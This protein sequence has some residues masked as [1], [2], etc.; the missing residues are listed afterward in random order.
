MSRLYRLPDEL[1]RII[2]EYSHNMLFRDVVVQLLRTVKWDL[3]NL[4][5]FPI[6][7][8]SPS[9]SSSVILFKNEALARSAIGW[10]YVYNRRT[11]DMY[12]H[13]ITVMGRRSVDSFMHAIGKYQRFSFVE[14]KNYDKKRLHELCAQN[15]LPH[16]SSYTR[17][18]LVT[19]LLKQP[20]N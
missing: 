11:N 7:P 5:P 6:A 1:L 14:M 4:D 15:G 19:Y 20:D 10:R 17:D 9:V 13:D 3:I 18:K 8:W 12:V 16:R 2:Y